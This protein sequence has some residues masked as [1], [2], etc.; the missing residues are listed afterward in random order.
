MKAALICWL[1]FA[2]GSVPAAFPGGEAISTPPPPSALPTPGI[3]AQELSGGFTR[4]IPDREGNY[5]W[6]MEGETVS[7]LSPVCL[8]ITRLTATALV[9]RLEGLTITAGRVIYFTD[10]G[11]ARHDE[12]RIS[13]RREKMFLSG[14]G[15]LWTPDNRQI[16][17][18]ED[19]RLLI[20]EGGEG[21][22]FPK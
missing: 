8:E 12:T 5:E 20:Q 2:G 3:P 4:Y 13:V 1:L 22:L 19:V 6:K 16:R 7:F 21:G 17:V 18:F 15:F 10:S 9:P 11:I 14:K